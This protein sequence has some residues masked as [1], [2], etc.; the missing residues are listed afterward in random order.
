MNT[1]KMEQMICEVVGQ[2]HDCTRMNTSFSS[3]VKSTSV[4]YHR[5]GLFLV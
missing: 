5:W 3:N 1:K 2:L 4:N